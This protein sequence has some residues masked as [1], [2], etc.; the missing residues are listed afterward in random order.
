MLST[1]GKIWQ[2]IGHARIGAPGQTAR[3]TGAE[4]LWR[5]ALRENTRA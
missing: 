1:G 2:E 4:R 5:G 3:G